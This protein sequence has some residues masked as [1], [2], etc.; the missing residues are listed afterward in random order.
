MKKPPNKIKILTF[1]FTI[2]DGRRQLKD[3]AAFGMMA[4]Y[5]QQILI[6]FDS[7]K[8]QQDTPHS[9]RYGTQQKPYCSRPK[10]AKPKLV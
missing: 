3:N 1:T 4:N 10:T 6:D 5:D 8:D 2:S 9:T 7:H